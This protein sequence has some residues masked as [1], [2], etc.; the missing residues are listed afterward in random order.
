MP[1]LSGIF[2][3][4]LIHIYTARL[5]HRAAI[6]SLEDERRV[7]SSSLLNGG[8]RSDLSFVFNYDELEEKT[9]RC[10]MLAPTHEEHLKIVAENILKLPLRQTTG[11]T[12]AAQ[13]LSLIHI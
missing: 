5:D 9:K 8:L 12:T 13:M 6:I 11:L 4:S 10:E 7:L 2:W 1:L 3:L